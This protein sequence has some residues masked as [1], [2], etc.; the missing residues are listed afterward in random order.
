M[1]TLSKF[2]KTTRWR[3]P[4]CGSA[5]TKRHTTGMQRISCMIELKL[6][7]RWKRCLAQ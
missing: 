5:E 6:G 3:E 4:D 2:E 1:S 7:S